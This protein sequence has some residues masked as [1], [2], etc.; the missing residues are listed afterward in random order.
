MMSQTAINRTRLHANLLPFSKGWGVS[1]YWREDECST[2][3]SLKFTIKDI[4]L[5]HALKYYADMYFL[6][7]AQHTVCR[8]TTGDLTMQ[9]M[10]CLQASFSQNLMAAKRR[11][12]VSIKILLPKLKK[13]DHNPSLQGNTSLTFT[14]LLTLS[15]HGLNT[16][17][18]YNS[19]SG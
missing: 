10:M 14:Y 16:K 8:G 19:S 13:K 5:D 15:I 11:N 6:N 12:A 1:R 18:Q 4:K 2:G 7:S 17:V 9:T 3:N